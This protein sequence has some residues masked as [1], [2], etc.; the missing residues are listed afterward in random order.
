ME[1][2]SRDTINRYIPGISIGGTRV[3]NGSLHTGLRY[4]KGENPSAR[5]VLPASDR[6]L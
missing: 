6:A 2:M 1:G 3:R 5:W 4:Q